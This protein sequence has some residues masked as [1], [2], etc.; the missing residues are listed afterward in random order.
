MCGATYVMYTFTII[1][2]CNILFFFSVSFNVTK[3]PICDSPYDDEE[4]DFTFPPST[5]PPTTLP[6]DM[7]PTTLPP[8]V[9]PTDPEIE[10]EIIEEIPSG[11]GGIFIDEEIQAEPL[12]EGGYDGVCGSDGYSYNSTC[13]MA[14]E[15][16]TVDV[17]YRGTCY[18][19]RC[20]FGL[21]RQCINIPHY[22]TI[23][24]SCA[25]FA[26]AL[27]AQQLVLLSGASLHHHVHNHYLALL[28]SVSYY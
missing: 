3:G 6:P 25:Q 8:E 13:E 12:L 17:A 18:Q 21:V 16:G 5:A 22:P 28:P 19:G 20:Q 27:P 11:D 2:L 7:D 23:L 4:D 9:E 26:I 14:K 10:V 24:G 1:V 15:S